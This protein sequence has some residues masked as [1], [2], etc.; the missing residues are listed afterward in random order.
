MHDPWVGGLR[1]KVRLPL[2]ART[3]RMSMEGGFQKAFFEKAGMVKHE[4]VGEE[5]QGFS[6][7]LNRSRGAKGAG[8]RCIL[9]KG[10][11]LDV[12]F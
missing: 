2:N 7:V 11:L 1:Q 6:R 12:L 3:S 8:E 4:D 10:E 9:G 5:E